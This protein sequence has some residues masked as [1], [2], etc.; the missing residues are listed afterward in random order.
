[1]QGFLELRLCGQHSQGPVDGLTA[2]WLAVA[3]DLADFAD[4]VPVGAELAGGHL[5]LLGQP[6][7]AAAV[8]AAGRD[9][10]TT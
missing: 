6:V 4:A 3:E 9:C 7:L 2:D 10:G 8:P 5:L 1:M